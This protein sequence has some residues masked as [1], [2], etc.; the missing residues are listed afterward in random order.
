M[1]TVVNL[2]S[3]TAA[4]GKKGLLW[5][6]IALL[7]FVGLLGPRAVPL[8]QVAL[9]YV[10]GGPPLDF[11]APHDGQV[12]AHIDVLGRIA[13]GHLEDSNHEHRRWHRRLGCEAAVQ[14]KR[15]LEQLL[16]SEVP[17]WAEPVVVHGRP[18][19]V[20]CPG[21]PGAHLFPGARHSL[22]LRGLGRQRARAIRALSVVAE[23]RR[24][25]SRRLLRPGTTRPPADAGSCGPTTPP[26]SRHEGTSGR[27]GPSATTA[28]RT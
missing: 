19:G 8:G 22:S 7:V 23:V 18:S 9:W 11:D 28:A 16:E 12:I 15:V 2:A 4:V 25:G 26:R 27:S 17:G 6:G 10:T 24:R 20:C 5:L 13:S 14:S 3:R 21:A 1:S